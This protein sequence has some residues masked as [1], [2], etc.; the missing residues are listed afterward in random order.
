MSLFQ[1]PKD[2]VRKLLISQPPAPL[3]SFNITYA[4]NCDN[5][6]YQLKITNKSSSSSGSRNKK[7]KS[8]SSS[9]NNNPKGKKF[10]S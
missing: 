7:H 3:W 8:N 2:D 10:A 1:G 5:L 4:V 9:D 6:L